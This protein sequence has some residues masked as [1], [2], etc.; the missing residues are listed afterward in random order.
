MT[1]NIVYME[2]IINSSAKLH[3]RMSHATSRFRQ[4]W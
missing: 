1:R 3:G 2:E 4:K